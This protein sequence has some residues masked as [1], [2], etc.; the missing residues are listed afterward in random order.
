MKYPCVAGCGKE[1]DDPLHC[2]HHF[3]FMHIGADN[4]CQCGEYVGNGMAFHEHFAGKA[5]KGR[6]IYRRLKRHY[7]DCVMGVAEKPLQSQWEGLIMS[8]LQSYIAKPK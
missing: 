5:R 7:A 6:E 3:W 2:V 4:V 8:T 1:F